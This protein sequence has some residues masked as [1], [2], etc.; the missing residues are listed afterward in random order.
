VRHPARF[1]KGSHFGRTGFEK[2]KPIGLWSCL[3]KRTHLNPNTVHLS[4]AAMEDMRLP[5]A[6]S[7][8]RTDAADSRMSDLWLGELY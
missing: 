6:F 2:A 8:R 7:P 3:K 4:P 1:A 5:A